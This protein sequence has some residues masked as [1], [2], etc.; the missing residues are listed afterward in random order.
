MPTTRRLSAVLFLAALLLSACARGQAADPTATAAPAIAPTATT[1]TTG[2]PKV[3][4]S[5][6]GPPADR[7]AIRSCAAS[8]LPEPQ[9]Q[10]PGARHRVKQNGRSSATSATAVTAGVGPSLRWATATTT[11]STRS[12]SSQLASIGEAT[13]GTREEHGRVPLR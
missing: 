10:R 3:P 9:R 2:E 7:P 6:T 8:A 1:Q 12:P 13:S 11:R 5:T 4:P